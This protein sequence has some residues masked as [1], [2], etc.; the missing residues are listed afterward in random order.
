MFKIKNQI[1]NYCQP[2][3]HLNW[4]QKNALNSLIKMFK[5]QN[6]KLLL[7]RYRL[8]N[9]KLFQGTFSNFKNYFFLK[10]SK[11]KKK[12]GKQINRSTEVFSNLCPTC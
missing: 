3:K 5:E 2:N 7:S 4:L 8:K 12:L 6:M 9:R 10:I 1:L 11:G